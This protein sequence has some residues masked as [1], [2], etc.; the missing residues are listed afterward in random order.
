MTFIRADNTPSLK[1]HRKMGMR[2]LGPFMSEGVPH[3]AFAY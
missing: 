1:A 2:E 3:V